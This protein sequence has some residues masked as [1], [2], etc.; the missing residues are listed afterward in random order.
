MGT[1][2]EIHVMFLEETR[3]HIGPEG[4]GDAAIV[5]APA[6]DVLVGVGPEKIA[7]Q[8]AVRDL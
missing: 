8:A 2:D 7:K 3:D 6:G 1:A 5:F 4:E